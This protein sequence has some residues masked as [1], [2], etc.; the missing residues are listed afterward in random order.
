MLA[1]SSAMTRW[2]IRSE[3]VRWPSTLIPG[4]AASKSLATFSE[5][6][7]ASE[8]YQAT[9]PSFFAA[10]TR[11]SWADRGAAEQASASAITLAMR[12]PWVIGAPLCGERVH[13]GGDMLL[14]RE[15]L[16][17]PDHARGLLVGHGESGIA[18]ELRLQLLPRHGEVGP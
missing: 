9:L 17:D 12:R 16:D 5:L 7:S 6:D 2:R 11:A 8:V 14:G 13:E 10:S 1:W 4:Y 18:A 3:P 15:A